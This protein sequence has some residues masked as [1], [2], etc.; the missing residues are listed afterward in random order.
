MLFFDDRRHAGRELARRLA[1]LDLKSPVILGLPRG[2]VPVAWEA[3][4]ALDAPLDALVVRKIGAPGNPEV[5]VGA[6]AAGGVRVWN[7]ELLRDLGLTPQGLEGAVRRELAELERRERAY[8]G[9]AAPPDA[10]GKTAVIVDD[11]LAT[12]ATLRAAL[13]AVR[14]LRPARTVAAVPVAS[15]RALDE[16]RGVADELVCLQV[17]PGFS[18]VGQFYAD[19]S[20]T[21]DEEVVALLSGARA[22]SGRPPAP[23]QTRPRAV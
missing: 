23:A 13:L 5:A 20:P 11:G 3:A 4:R 14:R 18:A 7:D 17:P 12:G 6:V 21:T 22:R 19:F 1:G 2:G 10:A 16:L 15:A 9:G 8:R